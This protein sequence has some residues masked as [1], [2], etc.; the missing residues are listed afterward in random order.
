MLTQTLVY[1][2]P[3]LS[4]LGCPQLMQTGS[5]SN[6]LALYDSGCD[7]MFQLTATSAKWNDTYDYTTTRLLLVLLQSLFYSKLGMKNAGF[8][9]FYSEP[10]LGEINFEHAFPHLADP[11]LSYRSVSLTVNDQSEV[12]SS[13][14]LGLVVAY[15]DCFRQVT[16][17]LKYW[18]SLSGLSRERSIGSYPLALMVAFALQ[19]T[20]P[21]VLPPLEDILKGSSPSHSERSLLSTEELLV[22]FIAY[23]ADFDY[24]YDCICPQNAQLKSRAALYADLPGGPFEEAPIALQ[25]PIEEKKNPLVDCSAEAFEQ[26]RSLLEALAKKV[27]PENVILELTKPLDPQP[28]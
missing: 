6:G 11:C 14:L 19:Q 8:E 13:S 25:D 7:L 5:S 26:F 27:T 10:I 24:E 2:S 9:L 21:P 4:A 1:S 20:V 23:Y 22:H 12:M 28:L 3:E 17:V 15:D 16:L 18:H